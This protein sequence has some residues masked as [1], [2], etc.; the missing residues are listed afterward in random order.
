MAIELIRQRIYGTNEGTFENPYAANRDRRWEIGIAIPIKNYDF[1]KPRLVSYPVISQWRTIIKIDTS[2]VSDTESYSL[3]KL[4]LKMIKENKKVFAQLAKTDRSMVETVEISGIFNNMI[5]LK[6]APQRDYSTDGLFTVSLPYWAYGWEANGYF[7]FENLRRYELEQIR[8]NVG[9]FF[10]QELYLPIDK[11]NEE[12]DIFYQDIDLSNFFIHPKAHFRIG[13][14]Y[15][16]MFLDEQGIER[17]DVGYVRMVW[18]AGD[19][20]HTSKI[21]ENVYG[22]TYSVFNSKAMKSPKSNKVRIAISFQN[23]DYATDKAAV[24][25]WINN[26]WA[27]HDAGYQVGGRFLI[28]NY[29]IRSSLGYTDSDD[30][31]LTRLANGEYFM[32]AKFGNPNQSTKWIIESDWNFVGRET[33]N[34][35]KYIESLCRDGYLINL[36]P[37]IP[38][39]PEVLTGKLVVKEYSKPIFDFDKYTFKVIFQQV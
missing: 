31:D 10:G 38:E 11:F 14:M 29:P 28:D 33:Y 27:E 9:D 3:A 22:F 7:H 32:D 2:I 8:N 23:P 17:T 13:C 37:K 30:I 12:E 20:E 18:E 34:Q 26:I 1:K 5:F 4:I 15:N 24:R 35:F 25:F 6:V 19:K 36:H 39:V 21:N 16:I